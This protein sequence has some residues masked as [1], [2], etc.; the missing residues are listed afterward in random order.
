MMG[1]VIGVWFVYFGQVPSPTFTTGSRPASKALPCKAYRVANMFRYCKQFLQLFS[2][3]F[4]LQKSYIPH[5]KDL[6]FSYLEPERQG[7]W[8][9]FRSVISS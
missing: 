2:L 9:Q 6:I 3:T 8:Q 1:M 5:L 4:V 7:A